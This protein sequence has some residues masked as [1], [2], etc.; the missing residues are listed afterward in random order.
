MKEPVLT[1]CP[2]NDGT[3]EAETVEAITVALIRERS[4]AGQLVSAAELMSLLEERL[5]PRDAR[6][7]GEDITAM[8][9]RAAHENQDLHTQNG[10][11]SSWYYSTLS[12]TEA[13]AAILLQALEGPVRLIAETVRHNSAAYQRPVPVELFEQP[14]FNLSCREVT[15]SLATMAVTEGY[16]DIATTTTSADGMYLY[17]TT[18]LEP[19]HAEMLAEWFDVGQ[20]ENP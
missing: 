14:P 10:A 8:L 3:L 15:D 4:A 9:T 12:M 18:C 20:A 5:T 13:Y 2:D 6:I 16:E 19:G 11:G 17:S 1:D 7:Q